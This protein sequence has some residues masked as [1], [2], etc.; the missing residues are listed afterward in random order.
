MATAQPAGQQR[1]AWGRDHGNFATVAAMPNGSG[2][3]LPSATVPFTV[4]AGDRCYLSLSTGQCEYL[5]ISPG[6]A[7]GGDAVWV[8]SSGQGP[9]SSVLYVDNVRGSDTTG[10]RGN[11]NRPF[12]S[13]QAAINAML[14]GDTVAAAP[15]SFTIAVAITVPATVIR[16][17][18]AGAY[19]KG[20]QSA[21]SPSG[22]LLN[23]GVGTVFD[24]GAN[25]GLAKWTFANL[26]LRTSGT[27][28][29]ADG[30][31]YAK[32]AFLGGGLVLDNIDVFGTTASITAKYVGA[33]S[34]GN[35]N[36]N[37]PIS[38]T[39]GGFN[40]FSGVRGE[41]CAATISYDTADAKATT[42]HGT[43]VVRNGTALGG[44]TNTMFVTWS[45][46]GQ[47]FV[48]ATSS[49]GGL[50]AL[51][52]SVNGASVPALSCCGAIGS[53]NTNIV[54]LG[55]SGTSEIPDTATALVLDLRG[56]HFIGVTAPQTPGVFGPTTVRAKVAGAAANFQTVKLDSTVALPGCT[57][58]ADSKIHMT[59]RGA[60][61]PQ[62]VYTTPG[63][64]TVDGDIVPPTLGGIVNLGAS[65]GARTWVQLGYAGFIRAGVA[66]D[67]A[68][69][70]PSVAATDPCITALATTGLTFG[71]N[72]VAGNTAAN[73]EANWK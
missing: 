16:G 46:Q 41:N 67:Y 49:L 21:T 23:G 39:N 71:G 36:I 25:L 18:I 19:E 55:G 68:L 59:A 37:G 30:T 3:V 50:K 1:N 17:G 43:L 12:A 15:L 52:L 34:W 9:W 65:V 38:F 45:A 6:A 13:P 11:A 58:T 29:A 26:S 22:T 32:D 64:T 70:T 20:T 54:D 47:V 33:S 24:L 28:I 69:Y 35:C 51:N 27:C 31:A 44:L 40:T 48:D 2:N 72:V 5:C 53:A 73:W 57:F 7:A 61:F 56:T 63:T 10:Q 66:P 62:A 4:E 60:D 14:T 42:A 8:P